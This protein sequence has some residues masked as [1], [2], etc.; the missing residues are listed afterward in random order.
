[1]TENSETTP[2]LI[3][4]MEV[5][6]EKQTIVDLKALEKFAKACAKACAQAE[7]MHHPKPEVSPRK[8][9]GIIPL[10]LMKCFGNKAGTPHAILI[11]VISKIHMYS[12]E[13]LDNKGTLAMWESFYP[14]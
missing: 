14:L 8:M 2:S 11:S 13:H 3:D 5:A 7:M 4:F 1:M 12:T 6:V 9:L 10:F